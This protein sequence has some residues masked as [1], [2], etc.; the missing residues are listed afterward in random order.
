VIENSQALRDALLLT[1]GRVS[2]DAEARGYDPARLR[3][4]LVEAWRAEYPDVELAVD[5]D[6]VADGATGVESLTFLVR[7]AA[8]GAAAGIV[9]RFPSQFPDSF[10]PITVNGDRGLDHARLRARFFGPGS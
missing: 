6:F 9:L 3:Q 10:E 2:R 7:D 5:A 8:N 4:L 1:A